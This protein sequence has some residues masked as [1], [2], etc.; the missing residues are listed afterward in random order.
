MKK[1]STIGKQHLV[2][3][4]E[5]L[6]NLLESKNI[7]QYDEPVQ[8]TALYIVRKFPEIKN[9]KIKYEFP[10]PDNEPD[11]K[12]I[13][14]NKETICINL[15]SLKGNGKIQP[16]NLGARSFI[17]KYFQFEKI[18]NQF[19]ELL[20]QEYKQFLQSV[21]EINEEVNT[22]DTVPLLK[23][24]VNKLYPSFTESINPIRT[25]FLFNLREHLFELLQ[26]GNTSESD[27]IQQG[28]KELMLLD[29]INIVTRYNDKN[30]CSVIEKWQPVV[31]LEEKIEFY[32]KGNDTVGI[33][34]GQAALTLR[35]KFESAPTSSL[36][37][38]TSYDV[39]PV[40]DERKLLNR[41]SLTKFQKLIQK[42]SHSK[43]SNDSNAVGKCNEA[44]VYANFIG[45]FPYVYQVDHQ[46][47]ISMYDTFAP[48]VKEQTML[49]LQNASEITVDQIGQYLTEN[50]GEYEIESIQLV[51]QNYIKNRLDTADLQLIL[52][53]KGKKIT[54]DFSLKAAAKAGS[55]ITM[56]NPGI[57]TILGIEYFAI[58]T[59]SDVVERI[60]LQ[61][62]DGILTHQQSLEEVSKEL[63][64]RLS[65]AQQ[66][67]L[68][69][70]LTAILGTAPTVVTF[71]ETKQCVIKEHSK[72]TSTIHVLPETPTPI[73]TMFKWNEGKDQIKLRVKFSAG[74]S[75]G[76]SSLKLAG[77]YRVE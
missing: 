46:E 32:K 75:K 6:V 14:K 36:K 45:K 56:K 37:L 54:V 50:Y 33:R 73:N 72:I 41:Q 43:A 47:F 21:I 62:L 3:V 29:S 58:G 74:Q 9:V 2:N 31:N 11:L 69:K 39:F 18:Q 49:Y 23:K 20:E 1:P 27:G 66:K 25:S 8:K 34:M 68:R 35:F 67:N 70:G 44:L 15:F 10:N 60:K 65:T 7:E 59:M 24:K 5:A 4:H 22:Y 51:P 53:V 48:K 38:A 40:V 30:K 76:W 63:G 13:M 17:Q 42:N 16:K 77:E 57:G 28:F 19:N 55:Q 52:N 64:N 71:Y 26:Q 61:F 12:I